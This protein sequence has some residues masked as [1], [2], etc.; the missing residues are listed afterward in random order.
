MEPAFRSMFG[1]R[2]VVV[3]CDPY[4]AHA[5]DP[6][7]VERARIV[8]ASVRRCRRCGCTD[9]RACVDGCYWTTPTTCSNCLFA[10]PMALPTALY[11]G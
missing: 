5:P 9:G 2:H 11:R 4:F 1:P 10:P 6:R 7:M 8:S 3:D